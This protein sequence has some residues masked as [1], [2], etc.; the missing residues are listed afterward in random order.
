MEGWFFT[1][2]HFNGF[3]E[4]ILPNAHLRRPKDSPKDPKEMH[5]QSHHWIF[6]WSTNMDSKIPAVCFSELKREAKN[7]QVR[8]MAT[9]TSSIYVDR[10]KKIQWYHLQSVFFWLISQHGAGLN[11]SNSIVSCSFNLR[12][13]VWW[14]VNFQTRIFR[15]PGS[16]P[17]WGSPRPTHYVKLFSA[18]KVTRKI[19][20]THRVKDSPLQQM[21]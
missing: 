17:K 21:W 13:F 16:F 9:S 12:C 15:M 3:M 6:P 18:T 14:L 2:I 19:S 11:C 4:K 7:F 8:N 5:A 1:M 20:D 10:V